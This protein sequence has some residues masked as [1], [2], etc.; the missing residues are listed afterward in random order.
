MRV[1]RFVGHG[2]ADQLGPV[3]PPGNG[4]GAEALRTL[5]SQFDL[6]LAERLPGT[7]W[8]GRLG[9][10]VLQREASPVIAVPEGGWESYL[11]SRSSN[12]RSQIRRKERKLLA[13][14]DPR[15]R[16]SS[17]PDRLRED[18]ETLIRL[19]HARWGEER[20]AALR[21]RAANFHFEFARAALER[22]WLRLWVAEIQGRPVAAWYGFRFAG[23]ESYYQSGRDPR[24]DRQ[25]VGLVLMAHTIREA[26][27]DGVAEYRLLRGDEPYKDRL[28][29][30]DEGL[31]TLAVAGGLVSG[32]ALAGA[33]LFLRARRALRRQ[34][35]SP[36]S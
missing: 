4:A 23:A 29:T 14:H 3:G 10:H 7:G 31:E 33:P 28:A 36:T 5:A 15:F 1:A 8:T 2:P 12:F 17:D 35:A 21:S 20:S 11:S 32:A 16:L 24:W 13:E 30:G 26:M 27:S 18:L 22:G 9:G 34:R 25:S 19:H 6:L